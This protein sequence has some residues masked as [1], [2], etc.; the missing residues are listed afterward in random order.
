MTKLSI[1]G[2][3]LT[4]AYFGALCLIGYLGWNDFRNLTPNEWG[5]FLAGS[6]GPVAIFWLVLGFFQQGIE[7]RNS[8]ETLRLQTEELK[9]SVEQ[10]S[11]LAE[12]SEKQH[13]LELE[14][15]KDEL[16]QR[17]QSETPLIR[18]SHGGGQGGQP[19]KTKINIAA[20]GELK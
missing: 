13:L 2:L 8:V 5:D 19:I 9:Q 12:I 1:F 11:R 6:L 18:L 3:L 10:Q 15:R 17:L 4:I 20:T 16:E 14:A 7:L